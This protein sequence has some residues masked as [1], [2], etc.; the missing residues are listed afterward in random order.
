M[1]LPQIPKIHIGK[2]T[3]FG[4]AAA[5]AVA[6]AMS[7]VTTVGPNQMGLRETLGNVTSDLMKP[8][9]SFTIPVIQFTHVYQTNTQK[10]DFVAGSD[11]WT[12]FKPSTADQNVLMAEVVLNFKVIP[13]EQNLIYH[14]WAMR[15]WFGTPNGY[16]LVTQMMND[17]A[18]AVL[19]RQTMA[20]ALASPAKFESDYYQDLT[21]RLQINNIPVAIE[22]LEL[23]KLQTFMPTRTVAYNVQGISAPPQVSYKQATP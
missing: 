7:S 11:R 8:G 4:A 13:D 22:S 16:F 5:V 12:P 3:A 19:G 9:M 17:S 1:N 23:K 21:Q 15:K 18:N 2:R 10:I 14:R 6:A 20:Q